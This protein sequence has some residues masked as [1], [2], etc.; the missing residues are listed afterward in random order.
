MHVILFKKIQLL[1]FQ[2]IDL[3]DNTEQPWLNCKSKYIA[4]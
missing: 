4:T 3:T 1:Y 2:I